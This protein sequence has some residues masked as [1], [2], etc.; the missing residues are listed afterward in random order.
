MNVTVY[1]N[2]VNYLNLLNNTYIASSLPRF[3]FVFQSASVSRSKLQYVDIHT[4]K[5]FNQNKIIVYYITV[6][7]M[8]HRFTF[9]FRQRRS[10]FLSLPTHWHTVLCLTTFTVS[11][12]FNDKQ[13]TWFS[14]LFFVFGNIIH[15]TQH[16]IR[17]QK[18]QYFFF[19]I[20]TIIKKKASG[21]HSSYLF[22]LSLV[23][24][25]FIECWCNWK[26][27][28][29]SSNIWVPRFPSQS[30]NKQ[31]YTSIIYNSNFI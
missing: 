10:F 5:D 25:N 8:H 24:F 2:S 11:N 29:T 20:I 28:C 16:N 3:V 4:S 26:F 7:C 14:Y 1:D 23:L 21:K 30:T 6:K 19:W 22:A 18:V 13:S 27:A 12:S 15:A 9:A 31:S 17:T